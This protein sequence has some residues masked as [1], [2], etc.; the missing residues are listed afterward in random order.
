MLFE[1]FQ[2]PNGLRLR[3]RVVIAPMTTYS[4]SEDGHIAPDELAFL[5]RRARGGFGM[6]ITAACYVHPRG[7]AFP[8]Q[9]GCS[10][11]VFL[12][13]L[14]SAAFAIKS[15]GAAAIL[16]IHHGGRQCPSRLC[17][18]PP[19]SASAIPSV[20]PNAETPLA[21]TEE[22]IEETIEAF[23]CATDRAAKA[24]FD[25]VEIHGAN[26]YL[27]QQFVSPHSNRRDD[28]WGRDRL[29]FALAVTDAVLHAARGRIAVGYRFSPEEM[30]TPGI[31]IGDTQA[32]LESLMERKLDWL[33]ISLGD[34]RASSLV[35]DYDDKTLSKVAEWTRGR[36]PLIGVGSI[37]ERGEADEALEMGADLVSIGRAAVSEPEW[38]QRAHAGDPVRTTLPFATMEEERTLPKGLAVRIR[39]VKGWFQV[40]GAPEA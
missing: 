21:M 33:H 7:H 27:L 39:S 36:V 30:E 19:L 28:A 40:E 31:R 17:D 13:S 16:Q 2:L 29:K 6:I 9:W 24:G 26:T 37:Q 8:G 22:E 3:N 1:P 32:L 35:G 4:S 15:G 10:S 34:Y 25:G 14:A 12:P 18:G 38:V 23:S 20:R 5:E 11:D